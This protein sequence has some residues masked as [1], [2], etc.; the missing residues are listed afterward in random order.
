MV[1]FAKLALQGSKIAKKIQNSK[2]QRIASQSS[3]L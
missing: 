3:L 1:R 2:Q